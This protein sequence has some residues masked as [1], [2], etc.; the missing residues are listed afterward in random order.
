MSEL[1]AK[2]T[3]GEFI[4]APTGQHQA[5]CVD[6][7]DLGMVERENNGQKK[8]R[9]EIKFVFQIAARME[10]GARYL[11]TSKPFN[12]SLHE[13]SSLRPFLENWRA[14]SFTQQ[15][16]DAGFH[17]VRL[18]G[19]NAL[20]NIVHN[21]YQGKLFA[22]IGA[23][24]PWNTQWGAKI[25]AEN[26]VRKADRQPSQPSA[27][28]GQPQTYSPQQQPYAPP[29]QQPYQPSPSPFPPP[30]QYAQ[31]PPAGQFP[32]QQ[33]PPP[34]EMNQDDIPFAWIAAL[35]VPSYFLLSNFM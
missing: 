1:I 20:L 11:I 7:I 22:N 5:V 34:Q 4:P 31:Q 17:V 14:Q 13:N 2:N 9:H 26:Y 29:P 27:T 16:I 33:Q 25:E 19:V 8:L 24:M 6:V 15:E 3:G 18:L 32:A 21:P 30:G 10:D 12:L 28:A 23:I 35:F